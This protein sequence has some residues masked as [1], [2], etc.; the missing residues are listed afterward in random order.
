[1]QDAEARKVWWKHTILSLATPLQ[2]LSFST[3]CFS[4][5]F[6]AD[7]IQ[8][9]WENARSGQQWPI[10]I[11]VP[12]N[13][14]HVIHV[15]LPRSS[16]FQ[17]LAYLRPSPSPCES[18]HPL[19]LSDLSATGQWSRSSVFVLKITNSKNLKKSQGI[20]K[21]VKNVWYL[22]VWKA[23]NKS[24][25]LTSLTYSLAR[26]AHSCHNTLSDSEDSKTI[27]F[28]THAI[29]SSFNDKHR[30]KYDNLI[31]QSQIGSEW[32]NGGTM[33]E[34]DAICWCL[35]VCIL[36]VISYIY[37]H[38]IVYSCFVSFQESELKHCGC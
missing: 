34:Y 2:E 22:Q 24:P 33:E 17:C 7:M 1:M 6:S 25:T 5:V 15:G 21:N 20:P 11:T 36:Y 12:L 30:A 35:Y 9:A 10:P 29:C 23:C 31:F 14:I 37:I 32:M 16:E 4:H 13:V 3:Y 26:T 19:R 38:I 18:G 28:M 27:Q 8:K